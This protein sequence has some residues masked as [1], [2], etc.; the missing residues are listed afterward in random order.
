MLDAIFESSGQVIQT[1]VFR[2][3]EADLSVLDGEEGWR[4]L[5]LVG[6]ESFQVFS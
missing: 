2:I 1:P 5:V 3:P 6:E 4:R